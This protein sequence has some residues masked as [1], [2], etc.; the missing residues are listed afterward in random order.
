MPRKLTARQFLKKFP[1]SE[2][3]ENCLED[4]GCPE[5]GNRERFKIEM[6]AVIEICDEGTEDHGDTEWDDK[7]YCECFVCSLSG[8]VR[9]FT[10]K[11]LDDLI[12]E[13]KQV[14]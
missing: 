9:N 11:G 8:K 5:C 4:M 14:S 3:N 7:S 6:T 2:Q 1:D 12:H 10:F 13:T